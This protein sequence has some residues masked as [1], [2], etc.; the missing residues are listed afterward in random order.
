RGWLPE[1][2]KWSLLL[3]VSEV[4]GID[5]PGGGDGTDGTDGTDGGD[6]ALAGAVVLTRYGADLTS[7]GMMLVAARYGRM[8]LGRALMEHLLAEAGDATVTLFATDLGKP[9][10]DKLG[11][12]TIRRSAAFTGPFRADPFLA[13]PAVTTATT[14]NSKMRTRPAAAA[15]MASI[16]DVDKAAFGADRSRL[17]RRLPAFAGQLLVLETGRSIA[18]FAAAWQNHTST[19]IG[20]VV[21]PDG[22][23]ARRLIGDL[24]AGIRGQVRLDLDPDRPELPP[25]AVRHGLQ[26]AG[27]NAVMAYGDRPPP[28]DPARLFTPISIALA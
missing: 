12:R 7:V 14:D 2:A 4:F 18:G 17:L 25:W 9:L 10:Y 22:A 26:P 27:L 23:A 28:G 8:G 21:A 11:F 13:E 3:E 19:V 15:D 6:R 24:A 20:P 16:I 1:K 5:A